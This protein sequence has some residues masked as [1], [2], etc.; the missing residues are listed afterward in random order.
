MSETLYF[1]KGENA[2]HFTDKKVQTLKAEGLVEG[3]TDN[4]SQNSFP[5][6]SRCSFRVHAP[7]QAILYNKSL[8]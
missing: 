3:H 2:L 1:T 7:P 4:G 8:T 6:A 5:T